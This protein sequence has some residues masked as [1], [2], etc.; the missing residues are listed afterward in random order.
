MHLQSWN[1]FVLR[2][3]AIAPSLLGARHT[4]QMGGATIELRLPNVEK[5]EKDHEEDYPVG[6]LRSWRADDGTPLEYFI[7]QVDVRVNVDACVELPAEVLT[8][9]P[10][11]FDVIP[12]TQ[13]NELEE[14]AT[15]HR[16]IATTAYEYWLSVMRWVCDD[17]RI[18]RPEIA[19]ND[20]GWSTYLFE[21]SSDKRI[22]GASTT[23]FVDGLHCLNNEEWERAQNILCQG[24]QVPIYLAQR[25]DAEA[26][27]AQHDY[28]RC[29]IDLCIAAETFLRQKV[30][31]SL[32][33]VLEDDVRTY[34]EQAN[35]NRYINSFFP[36]L[37][38]DEQRARYRSDL[39]HRLND[40][41]TVRNKI[42]H[43]GARNLASREDCS[44]HVDAVRLLFT[45][46]P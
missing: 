43:A 29:I 20:S 30:W 33:S 19:G 18:G 16:A 31:A 6:R 10:N 12:Q 39:R 5:I 44:A 15:R 17:Y 13:Q 46:A 4:W 34:V 41:F 2:A 8:R 32:P 35:I 36:S 27:L 1:R 14:V 25:Q 11:A 3:F 28:R 42:M 23:L 21:R 40:L 45:L 22:W 7:H 24:F 26:L 38:A 9:G 37:L